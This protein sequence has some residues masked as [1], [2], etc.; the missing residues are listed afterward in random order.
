MVPPLIRRGGVAGAAFVLL[1]LLVPFPLAAQTGESSIQRQEQIVEARIVRLLPGVVGIHTEVGGEVTVRCGKDD[2]YTLKP[3]PDMENGTGFLIHPDG[4][5]ATNGHVVVPVYKDDSE[6]IDAFLGQAANAAC[7]PGL[8][9]L[10]EKQRQARMEAILKDPE[11]QKGVKFT[12]KLEI[13][14]PTGEFQQ[15]YP[16]VV[17][18]HDFLSKKPRAQA[19]VTIGWVSA[20][21]LDVNE[22]QI[23]QTDA[24]ISW[25]NRGAPPS[26]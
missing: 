14:L 25:G 5:I 4:W 7:C 8:A 1:L 20:F 6:H 10:P 26:T 17:V 18:W 9:K 13:L 22:R 23:L 21:R 24:A 11:N 16:A 12:K 3:Q 2:A 19:R 15:G